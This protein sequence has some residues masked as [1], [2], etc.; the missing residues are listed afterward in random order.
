[1]KT[2]QTL[3]SNSFLC[4][5]RLSEGVVLIQ[6]SYQTLVPNS[7]L[8]LMSVFG[9][10]GCLKGITLVQTPTLVTISFL[11]LTTVLAQKVVSR[12]LLG[13]NT[14]RCLKNLSK[15]YPLVHISASLSQKLVSRGGALLSKYLFLAQTVSE[16]FEFSW[17]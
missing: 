2:F 13:S 15:R 10:K 16:R 17:V 11:W 8:L 7:F 12:G 3:D 5:K 4:I 14:S 1:M 6:Q 9:S